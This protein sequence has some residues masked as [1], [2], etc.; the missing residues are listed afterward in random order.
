MR[1]PAPHAHKH[2]QFEN[3]QQGDDQFEGGG[4]ADAEDVQ[5]H[6][7]NVGAA[8][9]PFGVQRRELDV[10]IGA[11]RH[12]NRR[13]GKDKL[14]QGGETGNKA[15]GRTECAVGVSEWPARMRNGGGQL[16]KAKDKGAVHGGN[17][18]RHNHKAQ[19]PGL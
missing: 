3:R 13:R 17:R 18:Q 6:K 2:Q 15:T 12:G 19:G 5:R 16:G 7:D 14:N 9:D 11:D 10:K 4:N 8:G 1:S